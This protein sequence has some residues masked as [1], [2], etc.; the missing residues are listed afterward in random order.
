MGGEHGSTMPIH[1]FFITRM[2]GFFHFHRFFGVPF[3]A[4]VLL[5]TIGISPAQADIPTNSS[6]IH[7]EG[8]GWG[9]GIGMSQY[10]AY[11]R[12]LPIGQGGGAQTAEQ[13]LS[14]YYPGTSLSVVEVPNDLRV[15][16]FSGE[17]ATFTTSGPV[18]LL[19]A[20]GNSFA[21]I[22][23][24]TV[25]TIGRSSSVISITTP[26]NVDQ[27]IEIAQPENIQHCTDG[28]IS[29]DLV[30]GE[31]VQTDVIEQFTDVGTS[32]NSYQW[33][34][35]VIRERDLEGD[36]VFV[37]LENLPME[38]YIYGLAEVSPS[39]P[40]AALE[41]QAIAGRSYALA[42]INS[43]RTSGNWSMPWDLYS[44]INDQYYIG[45]THESANNAENWTA[46]VEATAGQVLLNGESPISAY[47][48]SSN[49]GH[50][51]AGAYVFCTAANHPCPNISYLPAQVDAFDSVGNPYSTWER[52][53]TGEEVASWLASS[54]VGSVGA[55]TG[56]YVSGDF[57]TSGR[58][59][60]A[61]VTIV[62]TARTAVTKG[63]N[64]MAIVNSGVIGQGGGY[65]DQ[66]LST[67]YSI[68]GMFGIGNQIDQDTPGFLSAGW[69]GA[70]SG[71]RFGSV[72]DTGDF[73]GD[74][75]M[76]L[77]VG[78]P[79]ESVGAIAA[80]G[81][82]HVIYGSGGWSHNDGFYQNTS[83]WPDVSESGDRFGSALTTGDFNNDGFDDM[84]IG[85]PYED[86]GGS[87]QLVDAGIITVAYG[88]ASGLT[89]PVNLHQY[90]P[91]VGTNSESGDLFGAALASGD[92]NGDGYDDVIVG[93]PGEGIS[94]RDRA[95][96]VHVLY[97]SASGLT[98]VG[99]NLFHQDARGVKSRAE[100]DD[101][102]G[103][104]VEAGDINGDGYDDVIVGV[105][106]EGVG[107]GA[108]AQSNAGAVHVIYGSAS[109]ASGTGSQWFYQ[110]TPGWPGRAECYDGFGA[111]F[112]VCDIDGDGF[113]DL[114]VGVPGEKLG[115]YAEA[116]QVQIRYNPGNWSQTPASVQT[117]YQNVAGV[118][119]KV[120]TGDRFGSHLEMA[121]V[122]G[123]GNIDLIV[124][125]PG[126]SIAT[127][128]N[129]GAVAI[130]KS[131]GGAITTAEDQILYANQSVFTGESEANAEFGAWFSVLNGNLI[132][133]S[134]GRTVSG[135][136]N[137]G[138][139]Y[140][141]DL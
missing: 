35:L 125:V 93:V 54:S 69:I 102:F 123:D 71:D 26:D 136:A 56:I 86:L 61:N 32:G 14:F 21:S 43:R 29:I 76:D 30:E 37:I 19:N 141:L 38:K 130:F 50:S 88:S 36:G 28:P 47:Y 116:G 82:V 129:A 139:F 106:G 95:G 101:A 6:V 104:A 63:D 8:N 18:D 51:E 98:G 3:F 113:G 140:Y 90:S 132:I 23:A 128:P 79:E 110:N 83:G 99:S 40:T 16:I 115:N 5:L 57:G 4:L 39:W 138:A 53:Y 127:R 77:L 137:A 41:S 87:N 89:N 75:R 11:G 120:E 70:E 15:H 20:S 45:Y 119:N 44:T 46:A 67:L 133:G 42:H 103:E 85:V 27:C 109:G 59:D 118:Q 17:G 34:R 58:T 74:G 122:T 91:G 60:Q 78:V 134:P 9:H 81:L 73:D 92:I 108:R 107:W 48:S 121:D 10:G 117:L 64:F 22:P 105:P 126:E 66:I 111:S 62:G 72:T 114:V 68:E 97:G 13:I 131:V 80:G 135:L 33:G 84:V 24:Q 94:K 52:D 96:A 25:L 7:I 65:G 2:R 112:A 49:G 12:A 31:P 1:R 55:I 124:G 100:V